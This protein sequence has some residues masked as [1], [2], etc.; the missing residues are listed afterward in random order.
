MIEGEVEKFNSFQDTTKEERER[1]LLG[2]KHDYDKALQALSTHREFVRRYLPL[3]AGRDHRYGHKEDGNKLGSVMG[4]LIDPLTGQCITSRKCEASRICLV[5]GAMV[6]LDNDMDLYVKATA[7]FLYENIPRNSMEK[8][9]IMLNVRSGGPTMKNETPFALLPLIGKL[10]EQL[11]INFPERIQ[12]FVIYPL[13]WWAKQIFDWV[14][15]SILDPKTAAKLSI[16]SGDASFGSAEP[17]GLWEY[18]DLERIK[19]QSN[20][21]QYYP[22]SSTTEDTKRIR[23]RILEE[24]KGNY[25]RTL[26]GYRNLSSVRNN[27]NY[28]VYIVN[29]MKHMANVLKHQNQLEQSKDLFQEVFER[30]KNTIRRG[31]NCTENENIENVLRNLIFISIEMD[32]HEEARK[33]MLELDVAMK[34]GVGREERDLG[35]CS[36]TT[37]ASS[38]S[39]IGYMV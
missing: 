4:M 5:Q 12:Q 6:D 28:D 35:S 27:D 24:A 18:V 38:S 23:E 3:V 36:P 15:N 33:W 37:I 25:T 22:V 17:E 39:F 20:F 19:L 30:M 21:M 26:M 13:P 32:R 9:T 10:N 7:D 34:D 11:S 8:I 16:L 29:T 31:K 2:N 1:F 14:K